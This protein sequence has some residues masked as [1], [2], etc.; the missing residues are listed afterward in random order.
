[1]IHIMAVLGIV[2]CAVLLVAKPAGAATVAETFESFA[3]AGSWQVAADG[4]NT[5]YTLDCGNGW[6]AFAEDVSTS[7]V[8]YPPPSGPIGAQN[9]VALDNTVNGPSAASSTP[10]GSAL[11]NT[12]PGNAPRGVLWLLKSYPVKAGIPIQ[13]IQADFR[14]KL[15]GTIRQYYGIALFDGVVTNPSGQTISGVPQRSDTLAASMAFSGDTSSINSDACYGLTAGQWCAWQTAS[16]G[17]QYIV[18][19]S[20]AITVALRLGDSRADQQAFA[21][22]DNLSVS[23]VVTEV[24]SPVPVNDIAQLW[25]AGYQAGGTDNSAESAAIAKDAAGNSYVVG[26]SYNSSNFDIVTIKYDS[27]GNQTWLSTYDGGS[28]DRAVA[29]AL[30]PSNS[31]YVLGSKSNGTNNDYVVIKYNS[32][33]TQQWAATFDNAGQDDVPA[34]LV[35]DGSGNAYV[36]GKS[37]ST[38]SAC[39]Y[40]TVSF[41]ASDGYVLWSALYNGTAGGDD[42]AVGV[43]LDGSNNVY[44]TGR[45]AGG[46]DDIV[47]IKYNGST[48]AEIWKQRY[49]TGYDE[50]ATALGVDSAGN[51]YVAGFTYLGGGGN[52][53]ILVLK[54][55]PGGGSPLWVKTYGGGGVKSLPSAMT[56]DGSGNVYIV[57]K[58]GQVTNYDMV[59]IKYLT[60]GTLAWAKT[61]GNAGFD[62]WGVDIAVDGAGNTYV[63]GALTRTSGNTDFVVVRY[64]AAGTARNAISYD[65]YGLAETPAALAL[66][67]DAQGD[68]IPYITGTTVNGTSLLNEI[69]T[70]RYETAR[71][72]L[73]M[74]QVSG[75]LSVV[76]GN[77]ISVANTVLNISD[78]ANKKYA[79]SGPFTVG[80]Y[81][82]PVSGVPDL[83]HLTL[84]GTRLITNLTEGQSSADSTSVTIPSTLAEG[85]YALVAVADSGGEVTEADETNNTLVASSNIAITGTTPDLVVSGATGPATATRG[86]PFSVSATIANL[87]STPAS[88]SF[89]VGIYVSTDATI[90]TADTL[91][92]SYSVASLAGFASATTST[93]ATIPTSLAPGTYYLG[94][95][96]DDQNAVTEFNEGNNSLVIV[97]GTTLST[98]L[99]TKADF[100]AGLPGTNVAVVT[101]NGAANVRLA[102]QT[103]TW[104]AQSGWNLPDIGANSKPAFGDLNGDGLP[105]VLVG[106]STGAVSAYQNTGTSSAP[107]WTAVPSWG[108][109]TLCTISGGTVNPQTY[110]A[111]KLVDLNNDGLLDLVIGTRDGM[112]IYKNTGSASV[113]AWTL[114]PTWAVTGL[115]VNNF[116]VPA[117]KDLDNDGKVDLMLGQS[118][119]SILAYRNSG[120]ATVPA[121]TAQSSWQITG[122]TSARYSPAMADL[123]GDGKYDLMTGDSNGIVAAYRNTG[124][125]S[126]P[127]WTAN[128]AWNLA[129]PNTSTIN[130]AGPVLGDLNGDGSIDLLSGDISGVTFA[131]QNT[132]LFA[133]SGIYTSKVVDAGTHGGFTTLAYTA[134]TPSGTTLTVDVR[135]G[136]TAAPDGSWT[137]WFTGIANGG[138]I[139]ALGTN[140]YVQ[141]R[142]NPATANT[143]V[144]P[145]LFNIQANTLP[146][147]GTPTTVSVVVGAG[148]GGGGLGPMDVVMMSLIALLGRGL[149]RRVAVPL[150]SLLLKA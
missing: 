107:A 122:L 54:Y 129:D 130:Y 7:A 110:S 26:R 4:P 40:A 29:V 140:R 103:I 22:F 150:E 64:D 12:A 96:V 113:P 1:M 92:G 18:P 125:A 27:A 111:P 105:D 52:P 104:T 16:L 142:I 93:S 35:V 90:T 34:G 45:S 112:C 25:T 47:T 42:E 51:S 123:D 91:I 30:G 11:I 149:G 127:V 9:N 50:R 81:V 28:G 8:T 65:K 48:G 138:A 139:S 109:T 14:L 102:Q 135:A 115:A 100:L 19:S 74:T 76:V 141:Y 134:V 57:G 99:V 87:L 6:T 108:L 71:P 33:G 88:S 55:G 17:G 144:T 126:A 49:D 148:G 21:E 128:S 147:S 68:S 121:W 46:G 10:L 43:K 61:F 146:P 95:I 114:Q 72:D 70:V 44:V 98:L 24:G 84:L 5:S 89:R 75:P 2:T 131:Y 124:T 132:G 58:T 66:G 53:A 145:A 83:A 137:S 106:S 41:R 63:L 94:V 86:T 133:T 56:I 77:T 79:Y 136:G 15:N 120:S 73:T 143:A 69:V 36:T 37:C 32:A 60:D 39:D 101:T 20:S 118:G 80:L 116:Y 3:C 13:A 67:T 23:N 62:D 38:A 31:V 82:A 59:T 119:T 78:L 85:T 117:L 97:T